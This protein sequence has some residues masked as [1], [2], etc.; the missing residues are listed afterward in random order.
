MDTL[1]QTCT[2]FRPF[3]SINMGKTYISNTP[4]S[5]RPSSDTPWSSTWTS[6]YK[7]VVFLGVFHSI[8]MGKSQ[9]IPPTSTPACPAVLSHPPAHLRG[10]PRGHLRGPPRRPSACSS[11]SWNFWGRWLRVSVLHLL[12]STLAHVYTMKCLFFW[13]IL[14]GSPGDNVKKTPLAHVYTWKT[15]MG[16]FFGGAVQPSDARTALSKMTPILVFQV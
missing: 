9:K 14:C 8:N 10:L 12:F 2:F 16:S 4:T 1:V 7:H 11:W 5:I 6:W 3:Y 15:K 13:P